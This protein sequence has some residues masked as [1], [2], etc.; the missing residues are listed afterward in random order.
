MDQKA[1]SEDE[2]NNVPVPPHFAITDGYDKLKIGMTSNPHTIVNIPGYDYYILAGIENNELFSKLLIMNMNIMDA[3]AVDT[4]TSRVSMHFPDQMKILKKQVSHITNATQDNLTYFTSKYNDIFLKMDI[5]GNEYLWALAMEKESLEK[6]KQ[7]MITFYDININPTKQR[8][9]NK[10]KCFQKLKETHNI[11]FMRYNGRHLI[12]TYVRKDNEPPSETSSNVLSSVDENSDED[13]EDVEMVN[14]VVNNDSEQKAKEE[15]EEIV[16]LQIIEKE[17]EEELART[18]AEAEAQAEA[19]ARAHAE[20]AIRADAEEKARA[21]E[22]ARFQQQAEDAAKAEEEMRIKQQIEA[23][24]MAQQEA[25]IIAEEE[26]R[27]KAKEEAR[28][29]AEDE[30]RIKAEDEARTKAEDETRAKAEDETRAKAE[31]EA[32]AKAEE[33][34]RAKAEDEAIAK[35][36]E[37]D[38][39]DSEEERERERLKQE[40]I[41]EAQERG[42][43]A[44]AEDSTQKEETQ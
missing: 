9:I 41:K 35:A 23:E 4:N 26:E 2:S 22:A 7:M 30:A 1:V 42:P 34:A 17:E 43:P 5:K 31:E 19:L 21:E 3:C 37:D 10:I 39:T 11:A 18:Q 6:F 14:E 24:A 16:R 38:A 25:R 33:E 13:V 12:V 44:L 15:Q 28:I 36:E 29:K 20:A 40:S 27:E 32:R 8:A